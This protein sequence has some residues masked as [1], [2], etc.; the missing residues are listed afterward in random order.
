[1]AEAKWA[2]GQ[3]I[4]PQARPAQTIEWEWVDGESGKVAADEYVAGGP[5]PIEKTFTDSGA[6]WLD[7][8]SGRK[9][10]RADLTDSATAP[11]DTLGPKLGYLAKLSDD[12]LEWLEID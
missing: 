8:L 7:A 2:D 9:S 6:A 11:T 5:M 4:L 3:S 1:M 10:H 12:N